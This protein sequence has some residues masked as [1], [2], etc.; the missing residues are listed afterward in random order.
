M[1]QKTILQKNVNSNILWSN[2]ITNT[3]VDIETKVTE[4]LL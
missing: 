2:A 3:I 4:I 1:D